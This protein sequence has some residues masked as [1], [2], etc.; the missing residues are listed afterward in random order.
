MIWHNGSSWQILPAKVGDEMTSVPFLLLEGLNSGDPIPADAKFWNELRREA[1]A[2][3]QA[4][5]SAVPPEE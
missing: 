3:L 4:S 5:K 2:K 1:L